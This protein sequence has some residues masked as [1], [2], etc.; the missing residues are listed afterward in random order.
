MKIHVNGIEQP[1][2]KSAHECRLHV[3]SLKQ[4]ITAAGTQRVNPS[5][6]FYTE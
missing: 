2:V 5:L 1:T 3:K 4:I 6:L